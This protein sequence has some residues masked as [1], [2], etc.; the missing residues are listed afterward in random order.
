[1]KALRQIPPVHDVLRADELAGFRDLLAEPFV[2]VIIDEVFSE[3]RRQL[4]NATGDPSRE[5]ITTRIA[6]EVARRISRSL[7][8]SLR[9]V[10]NASGVVL[11]TNLGRAPIPHAAIEHLG[12]VV[13]SY[14]NLE[15]DVIT[16]TRGKRDVHIRETLRQLLGCEAAIVVNNNAAAVLLVLNTLGE[17]GEVIASRGEQVEIGESFRIPEIMARSGARLREVGSTNRTRIK[18]YERAINEQTRLLLRVHPSNFRMIGFTERPS[19]QEFVELGR[20]RNIPTFEDLGS[21]CITDFGQVDMADEP[22]ARES[23][24]QGVDIVSFSGDKLLGGPQAGI[25]AG[26]NL[27]VEKVRQNPLFRALRV[28]KLTIAILEYVLRAYLR[29]DPHAIPIW[30]MLSTTESELR[31]RAETVQNPYFSIQSSV[32]DLHPKFSCRPGECAWI[33]RNYPKPSWGD[34]SD[35]QIHRS[36]SGWKMVML[37]SI[38]APFFLLKMTN[39]RGS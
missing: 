13:T 19:L 28:D 12:E 3:V 26:K 37:F 2:S 16:G 21:G 7:Q 33:F 15:F 11:H 14:S 17:G 30:R 36:S 1:M 38:S 34:A 10:I 31:S 18:D 24:R 4:V 23:I 25:I 27:Y 8:H 6:T 39:L 32:V 5:Q 22:L 9:R 29:G 20:K 35:I